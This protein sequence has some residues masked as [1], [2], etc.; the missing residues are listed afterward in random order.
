MKTRQQG[1]PTALILS[2]ETLGTATSMSWLLYSM[3]IN[4]IKIVSLCL[5]KAHNKAELCVFFILTTLSNLD[6]SW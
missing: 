1:P 5:L 2:F 4:T 6:S 3:R